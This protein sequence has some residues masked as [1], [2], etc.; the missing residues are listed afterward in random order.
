MRPPTAQ[1]AV[2]QDPTVPAQVDVVPPPTSKPIVPAAESH[3]AEHPA[4]SSDTDHVLPL[5][6]DVH[7]V[8]QAAALEHAPDHVVNAQVEKHK[9]DKRELYGLEPQGTIV[10]GLEDDKLWAMLRRFDNVRPSP[11]ASLS[12]F[13]V[14]LY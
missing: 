3:L 8:H 4:T 11:S 1:T 12:L 9:A 7:P 13:R 14:A 6:S 10:P 5:G 2:V